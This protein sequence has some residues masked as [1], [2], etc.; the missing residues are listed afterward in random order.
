MKNKIY[1]LGVVIPVYNEENAIRNVLD[2]WVSELNRLN[3]CYQIHAYNDGSK[4]NTIKILNEYAEYCNKVVVH[5]KQNTGHGSTILVGYRENTDKEWIFQTDS[6]DERDR[7][8]FISYGKKEIIMIF[9]LESG[10]EEKV[11]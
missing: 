8:H 7:N 3:I 10:K 5:N 2:K 11:L 1:E 9:S 6:D 4:D